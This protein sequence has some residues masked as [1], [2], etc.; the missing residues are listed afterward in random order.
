MNNRSPKLKVII[1]QRLFAKYREA[2][3][4]KID[5]RYEFKLLHSIN[6]SGIRQLTRKYSIKVKSFNYSN[7]ETSVILCVLF[8]FLKYKPQVIIHEFNP[9][10]ISLHTSLLY[11]KIF[12]KKLIVWGHGYNKKA[13]FNPTKSIKSR[14]RY[15]Y[16]KHSDAILLYSREDK[17]KLA[18]YVDAKKIFVAQNTLNTPKITK[19]RTKFENQSVNAIKEELGV[20]HEFN[21][22]YL[23]RLLEDKIRVDIFYSIIKKISKTEIDIG[24]H[25]IGGGEA[26]HKLK[27][28]FLNEDKVYFYGPLFC[29]E[30]VGKYLFISDLLL[31]PGYIGLSVV[32]S[33]FFGTPIF[34]FKKGASGPFHSP[35]IEYIHHGV[36]GYLAEPFN[37]NELVTS[38]IDFLNDKEKTL[39]WKINSIKKIEE[40]AL[41]DRMEAGFI[42]AIEYVK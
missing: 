5:S 41:I 8:K 40:E 18:N 22:I 26:Y 12:Q 1:V 29:E 19:L 24:V 36:N 31:N 13:G 30:K 28:K 25:I 32:Q 14:I 35:E 17:N 11:A 9:S 16:M 38:I 10:I 15:W 6:K 34:S 20:Q 2:I 39:N 21:I 3:Y 23:G 7:K 37:E 27:N 42:K 4:D 33:L